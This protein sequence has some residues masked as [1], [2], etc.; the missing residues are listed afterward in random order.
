[1][2]AA[3]AARRSA[4]PRPGALRGFV[5]GYMAWWQK[6]KNWRDAMSAVAAENPLVT[7]LLHAW[8][9][10]DLAARDQAVEAMYAEL[11]A[12]A[13]QRYGRQEQQT[14]QPAVL[15][16]ESLLRLIATSPDYK[17][18]GH[19]VAVAMLKM[20]SVLVD[21]LRAQSTDKRGGQHRQ[22][23]TLS[24]LDDGQPVGDA[25]AEVLSLHQGL[26]QLALADR[27]VAN[28]LELT[29]FAGMDRNEIAVLLEISVPTVDRDLRFGRAWLND[30]L[31]G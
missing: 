6:R 28:V 16:N 27:R 22:Q 29:Y 12:L 15:V 24:L 18:R 1:M 25:L 4:C 7:Q 21:H 10:G 13:R 19:F 17:D 3:V 20:R 23:V 26:D 11:L 9:Q 5:L 30:F 14:L 2:L 31:S 8:Q